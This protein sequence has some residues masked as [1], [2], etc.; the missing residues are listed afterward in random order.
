[1]E[2]KYVSEEDFILQIM[3]ISGSYRDLR[4]LA[5]VSMLIGTI[6]LIFN[7]LIVIYLFAFK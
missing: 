1:M 4:G 5:K 7:L 2:K 3:A 6:S